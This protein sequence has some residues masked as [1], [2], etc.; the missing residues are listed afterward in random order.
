MA[1]S[2]NT[3]RSKKVKGRSVPSRYKQSVEKYNSLHTS[4][5]TTSGPDK[6]NLSRNPRLFSATLDKTKANQTII[7]K[8]TI[9]K[10]TY[11]TPET[12]DTAPPN[13]DESAI[14]SA[15]CTISDYPK[16]D[17]LRQ[18]S[19]NCR[20]QKNFSTSVFKSAKQQRNTLN[21]SQAD[22]EAE[23]DTCY[24]E[25]QLNLLL[26]NKARKSLQDKSK[27]ALEKFF[28]VFNYIQQLM[29]KHENIKNSLNVVSFSL[30]LHEH[31]NKQEKMLVPCL[32]ILD[33]LEKQY[34]EI[35]TAI[36]CLRH[37]LLV[38]DVMPLEGFEK[39]IVELMNNIDN[40]LNIILAS[41]GN[42]DELV[43]S[44]NAACTFVKKGNLAFDEI[45]RGLELLAEVRNLMLSETAF[46][47]AS[48]CCEDVQT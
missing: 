44:T 5:E 13:F 11:S 46:K 16:I 29:G 20:E 7:P 1:S 9:P 45:K 48:L 42:V 21:Q 32:E 36:D 37:K 18:K 39:E 6:F 4:E 3:N 38:E 28:G 40:S 14:P 25:Y 31:L 8:K 27:T 17:R 33:E 43:T 47:F 34:E 12:V 30:E 15:S 19:L 10:K 41:V 26:E 22:Q 2:S 35:A 23:L 24:A